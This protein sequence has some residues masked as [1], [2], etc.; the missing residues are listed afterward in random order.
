LWLKCNKCNMVGRYATPTVIY[1]PP[2]LRPQLLPPDV[3]QRQ[4][5]L[6]RWDG[7]YLNRIVRCKWCDARDTYWTTRASQRRLQRYLAQAPREETA[8]PQHPGAKK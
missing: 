2:Q 5:D 1:L 6:T 7:V 3:I 4:P 8:L